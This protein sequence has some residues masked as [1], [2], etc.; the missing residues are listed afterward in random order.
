M[1]EKYCASSDWTNHWCIFW[2][3]LYG[4][5]N[6]RHEYFAFEEKK[7]EIREKYSNVHLYHV[8]LNAIIVTSLIDC[9]YWMIQGNKSDSDSETDIVI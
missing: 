9:L 5:N 4:M 7:C 8:H 3:T 6:L 1:C 2:D